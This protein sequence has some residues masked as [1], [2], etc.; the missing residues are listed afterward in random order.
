[1]GSN[2]DSNIR[3]YNGIQASLALRIMITEILY[4]GDEDDN[5][6]TFFHRTKQNRA[7]LSQQLSWNRSDGAGRISISS[8]IGSFL[9]QAREREGRPE[10]RHVWEDA[11]VVNLADVR[12]MQA[13]QTQDRFPSVSELFGAAGSPKMRNHLSEKA[14]LNGDLPDL[15]PRP[16]PAPPV[17]IKP[18]TEKE[19]REYW[20]E[21][22]AR[23]VIDTTGW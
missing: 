5:H 23:C 12:T 20:V 18:L 14:T 2:N 8:A 3:V 9:D 13:F 17:V 16:S 22:A 4:S 21:N 11:V 10:S 15:P 6:A 19:E 1:M 7:N